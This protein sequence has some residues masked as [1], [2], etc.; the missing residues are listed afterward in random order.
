MDKPETGAENGKRGAA[1]GAAHSG[2]AWR[3]TRRLRGADGGEG[4]RSGRL[5]GAGVVEHELDALGAQYWATGA[6][7]DAFAPLAGRA[8][9]LRVEAG[10]VLPA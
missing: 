1:G 9:M 7:E 6:D 2:H 8:H 3:A 5:R 4:S 10:G